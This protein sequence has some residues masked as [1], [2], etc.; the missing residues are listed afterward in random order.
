M[1]DRERLGGFRRPLTPPPSAGTAADRPRLRCANWH[2]RQRRSFHRVTR[3]RGEDHRKE[4][5]HERSIPSL[6]EFQMTTTTVWSTRVGSGGL[7]PEKT[8]SSA[9]SARRFPRVLA[10]RHQPP[11]SQGRGGP[12]T[13]AG[14]LRRGSR[15]AVRRPQMLTQHALIR[16][17]AMQLSDELKQD[18]IRDD[19]LAKPGRA[20]RGA[21]PPGRARGIPFHRRNPTRAC[22]PRGSIPAGGFRA[23]TTS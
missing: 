10:K 14:A 4:E 17:L 23:G 12:P 13:G 5:A 8:A 7:P 6:T 9:D 16:G 1:L 15:R 18:R 11:L 22:P 21:H 2:K 3:A 19:T 20:T